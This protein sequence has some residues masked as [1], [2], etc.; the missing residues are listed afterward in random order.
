MAHFGMLI[1][2]LTFHFELSKL[3]IVFFKRD[4]VSER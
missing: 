2:V 3:A 1:L 4:G